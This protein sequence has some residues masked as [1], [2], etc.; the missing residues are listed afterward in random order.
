ML[1]DKVRLDVGKTST[2]FKVWEN[3]A[4][5]TSATEYVDIYSGSSKL[6]ITSY[7][8]K[9]EIS[10]NTAKIIRTRNYTEKI[11][12][13]DTYAFDGSI[14]NVELFPI[15]HTIQVIGAKDKILQFKVSD[16]YGNI[17]S[18]DAKSPESFGKNMK[19]YWQDGAYYQKIAYSSTSKKDTLTV[20]YKI[21]SN[22]Q[23]FNVRVFDPPLS[24]VY[25]N[26][27]TS[28][29]NATE[30]SNLGARLSAPVL[31]MD[32]N[33]QPEM[34]TDGNIT[35]VQDNSLYNSWGTLK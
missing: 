20:K 32:F 30:S 9:Q 26:T 10:G 2:I 1:P 28:F 11:S 17:P 19:V 34:N 3:N 25:S 14:N 22:Q 4:W 33:T 35:Y 21:T 13:I 23:T 24:E 5:V 8:L 15:Y 12:I 27:S 18:R 29:F 31:S 7:N 6:G 16:L